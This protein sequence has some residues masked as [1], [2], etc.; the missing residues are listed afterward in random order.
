MLRNSRSDAE[1]EIERL[2][3]KIA[4]NAELLSN[5]RDKSDAMI[6]KLAARVAELEKK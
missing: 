6:E 4:E 5:E 2:K 1:H 3:R